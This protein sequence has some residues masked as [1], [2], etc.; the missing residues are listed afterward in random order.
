MCKELDEV[1]A[2]L[3]STSETLKATA[4][5]QRKGQIE[6]EKFKKES[7]R[8]RANSQKE[9]EQRK[10]EAE[11]RQKDWEAKFQKEAEQR[12]R[13]WEKRDKEIRSEFE[14]IGHFWGEDTEATFEEAT[15]EGIEIGGKKFIQNTVNYVIYNEKEQK[16]AEIDILMTNGRYILLIET[17]HNLPK[18]TAKER[19]NIEKLSQAFEKKLAAIKKYDSDFIK[20]KIILKAFAT[21]SFKKENHQAYFDKGY[22]IFTMQNNKPK[23]FGS[24]EK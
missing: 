3:K 20:G 8:W 10:K 17:K 16:A 13:E 19:K 14:R 6:F 1:K 11:Q 9:T 18:D 2:N 23:V 5:L 15:Q 21:R 22:L 4:E 24:I 7:E 12:K